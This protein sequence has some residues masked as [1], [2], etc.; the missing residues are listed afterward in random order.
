MSI[1]NLL[2]HKSVDPMQSIIKKF[3]K[4][5]LL[6]IDN[7][8]KINSLEELKRKFFYGK[9]QRF[10]RNTEIK[11]VYEAMI[12]AKVLKRNKI[13]EALLLTRKVRSLSG[14]AIV[15]VLTKPFKCPGKCVFC[16]S[17]ENMPKSYLSNEPAAA[18]AKKLNFSPYRQVQSRLKVLALNSHPIDKI[19]LIV[20]GGTF[21]YL[22]KAYQ[23]YFIKECFRATNDFYRSKNNK[24][25]NKSSLVQ[26]KKRNEKSSIRIVGLTLETRPDFINNKELIN[27]RRLGATRVELGVQAIDDKILKINKRGHTVTTSVEAIKLLKNFGF[28]INLHLMPGLPGSSLKKDLKMFQH[29]FFNQEF[30]PDLI[31]IYP[32]VVT[33]G[34]EI[35]H[36]WKKGKFK[37]LTNRQNEKLM[38]AIKKITP[39]YVRIA[40]LIRDIPGNSIIAGPNITNLRQKLKEKKIN[41]QCI[42]CREVGLNQKKSKKRKSSKEVKLKLRRIDYLASAGK[43]IFLEYVSWEKKELYALLRLRFPG[44]EFSQKTSRKVLKNSA[45]IRELH[46]YGKMVKINNKNQQAQQHKGL[47]KKLLKEAE[48]IVQRESDFE[49]IAIISGVGVRAYYRKQGYRLQNEYLVKKIK[50]EIKK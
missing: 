45:L 2:K 42:R 9:K 22:P 20:M 1:F 29:I 50:R 4:E 18:R 6:K 40:R 8:E 3:I 49:K 15:A 33:Q 11:M 48:K 30:Q 5:V 26:E 7:N 10:P 13:F 46:T 14:V 43:E 38:I 27:F 12:K 25:T 17:E 37:P 28:K 24:R 31:K 34:S 35:Y 47:G 23:N 16:P 41:C 39:P 21:S 32:C 36:W 19:E 44:K